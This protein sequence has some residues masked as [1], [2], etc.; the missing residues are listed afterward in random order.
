MIFHLCQIVSLGEA[1]TNEVLLRGPLNMNT[2][3]PNG[4]SHMFYMYSERF[5]NI[6][7]YE[8]LD[9]GSGIHYSLKI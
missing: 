2:N 1:F 7:L 9:G 8:G 4:H 6:S 5:F 3:K